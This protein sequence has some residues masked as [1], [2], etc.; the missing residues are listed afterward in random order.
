MRSMNSVANQVVMLALLTLITSSPAFGQG[1]TGAVL[2]GVTIT[3]TNTDTGQQR[4]LLTDERGNY[5]ALQLP[6]GKYSVAAELQGF[7]RLVRDAIT[8]QVDQRQQ[9]N[10]SLELGTVSENVTVVGE[11]AQVQTETA[12]VGAVVT[13][14]QAQE[15]PLNGRN[16]LQ[17]NLLVPGAI[18]TIKTSVLA[19]QGG[20]IVVHGL[21]DNQNSYWVD[22]MDNASQAIG[23]YVENMPQDEVQEFRV[24]STDDEAE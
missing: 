24:M 22:G 19:S 20:G 1:F 15:L 2:P 9:L 18:Q 10:F 6:P 11:A 3:V 8:L 4:A 13:A 16:F 5:Q 7:K 17:L 12:T 21:P 23:Q 14:Q